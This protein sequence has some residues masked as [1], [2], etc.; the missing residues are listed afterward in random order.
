L[1]RDAPECRFSG[2]DPQ[3]AET[4]GDGRPQL[5]RLP[6]RGSGLCAESGSEHITVNVLV[7]TGFARNLVEANIIFDVVEWAMGQA[8]L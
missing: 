6:A 1:G 7:Q 3:D 2:S 4:Y 8:S 5:P